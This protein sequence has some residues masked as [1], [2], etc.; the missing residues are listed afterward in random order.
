MKGRHCPTL[1]FSPKCTECLFILIFGSTYEHCIIFDTVLVEMAGAIVNTIDSAFWYLMI[2]FF[3]HSCILVIQK[4]GHL[5]L[6]PET[7][8]RPLKG[9]RSLMQ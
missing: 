2:Q 1:F 3:L 9:V 5:R 8:R 6:N 7:F 4:S